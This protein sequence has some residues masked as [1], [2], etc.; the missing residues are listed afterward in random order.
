MMKIKATCI[1]D[2]TNF[3]GEGDA[4]DTHPDDMP[5]VIS[6]AVQDAMNQAQLAGH[7]D[8]SGYSVTITFTPP[9]V[10]NEPD[11]E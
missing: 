2:N 5:G 6:G 1:V 11:A 10:E 4:T 9:P 7:D 3:V 8:L